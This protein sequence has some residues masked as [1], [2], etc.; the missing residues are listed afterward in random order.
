ASEARISQQ[1][2][3]IPVT[4]GIHVVIS[5]QRPRSEVPCLV[6]PH[7]PEWEKVSVVFG[8]PARI[9]N[10][11]EVNYVNFA[12]CLSGLL[13]TTSRRLPDLTRSWNSGPQIGKQ[14]QARRVA[15]LAW[16]RRRRGKCSR[17]AKKLHQRGK[18]GAHPADI[19][20]TEL[21]E[22]TFAFTRA[23]DAHIRN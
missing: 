1:V 11:A 5:V 22:E 23:G 2:V 20:R 9:V 10:V 21:F 8:G 7:W 13:E 19:H 18:S 16:P 15:D 14:D 17:A 4:A 12:A 3:E 6:R